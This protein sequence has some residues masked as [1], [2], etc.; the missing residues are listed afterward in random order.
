MSFEA[1]RLA[2]AIVVGHFATKIHIE[3]FLKV[4]FKT[5]EN[6]LIESK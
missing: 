3:T 1:Q 5:T 6:I 2:R 4:F